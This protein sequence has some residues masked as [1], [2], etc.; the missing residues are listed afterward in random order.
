MKE[1]SVLSYDNKLVK[2]RVD[3][4]DEYI[5]NQKRIKELLDSG[6]TTKEVLK[7]MNEENKK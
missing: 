4:K 2:V 1:V 3:K 7:I 5:K 6:L